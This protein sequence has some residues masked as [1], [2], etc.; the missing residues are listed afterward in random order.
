MP[1]DKVKNSDMPTITVKFL[2]PTNTLGA[3][4]KATYRGGSLT[5]PY[6][7]RKG[8]V[9]SSNLAAEALIAKLKWSG[10]WVGGETQNGRVYVHI[11][12][13]R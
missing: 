9:G 12:G 8:R 11:E 13:V 5:I 10:Q 4:L 7:H 1:T 6:D 2:G 3:R